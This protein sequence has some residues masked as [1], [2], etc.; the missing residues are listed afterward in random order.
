MEFDLEIEH[1]ISELV[2]ATYIPSIFSVG[3]ASC[4]MDLCETRLN[5]VI[6]LKR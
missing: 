3:G 5:Q 6:F 1:P 2:R 4:T